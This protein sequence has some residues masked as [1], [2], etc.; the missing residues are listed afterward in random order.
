MPKADASNK[1][2][3]TFKQL[4]KRYAYLTSHLH[5]RRVSAYKLCSFTA[6]SAKESHYLVIQEFSQLAIQ[7]LSSEYEGP[8]INA[9]LA[10][11]AQ[12]KREL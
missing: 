6:E 12:K 8:R 7:E 4:F 1:I 2:D 9:D 5:F 10:W 11:R 3:E